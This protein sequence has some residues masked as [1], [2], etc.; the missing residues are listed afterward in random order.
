MAFVSLEKVLCVAEYTRNAVQQCFLN[1]LD[2]FLRSSGRPDPL[3]PHK[4]HSSIFLC[5][6]EMLPAGGAFYR[7]LLYSILYNLR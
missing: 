3:A 2:Y 4:H 1:L 7:I 6:F 5:Y